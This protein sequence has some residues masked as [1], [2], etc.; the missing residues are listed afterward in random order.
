MSLNFVQIYVDRFCR[1]PNPMNKVMGCSMY[2]YSNK[3]GK[4]ICMKINKKLVFVIV[5]AIFVGVYIDYAFKEM[6]KKFLG[7]DLVG[8]GKTLSIEFYEKNANT[9]KSIEKIDLWDKDERDKVVKYMKENNLKIKPGKYV[10]N[11]G[12]SFKGALKKF[13]FEK[14]H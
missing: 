10:I 1:A 4:V 7:E 2:Y 13:E 5:L 14:I 9:Y 12:T 11:Q 6:D 3:K 8:I